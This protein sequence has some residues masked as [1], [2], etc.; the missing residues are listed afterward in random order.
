MEHID[1]NT[2]GFHL[3]KQ[4]QSLFQSGYSFRVEDAGNI[5]LDRLI[6][7]KTISFNTFSFET[8]QQRWDNSREFTLYDSTQK[9]YVFRISPVNGAPIKVNVNTMT[10]FLQEEMSMDLKTF[11]EEILLILRSLE[12]K[13]RNDK[14]TLLST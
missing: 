10:L 11:G 8:N 7:A 4:Q 14:L 13:Y 12:E 5:F 6:I 2:L 9:R 3:S 1:F